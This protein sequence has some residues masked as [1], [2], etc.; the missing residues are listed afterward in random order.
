MRAAKEEL[1]RDIT[2]DVN[3]FWAEVCVGSHFLYVGE[4]ELAHFTDLF[5]TLLSLLWFPHALAVG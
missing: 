4:F 2:A 1:T 5:E 3:A